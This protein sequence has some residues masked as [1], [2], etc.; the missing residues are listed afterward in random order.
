MKI[1]NISMKKFLVYFIALLGFALLSSSSCDKGL[2]L[3]TKRVEI[4]IL[5]VVNRI[6]PEAEISVYFNEGDFRKDKK[7]FA[8]GFSDQAGKFIVDLEPNT[9]VLDYYISVNKD[10]ADNWYDKIKFFVND[11]LE[12]SEAFIQITSSLESKLAGRNGKRWIQTSYIFNGEEF[13]RCE[14]RLVNIFKPNRFKPNSL[15][16]FSR[17]IDRYQS[18]N[19]VCNNPDKLHSVEVWELNKKEDG[20]FSS[21]FEK[22]F[23]ELTDTKMVVEYFP[24]NGVR[25]EE[26]F[27]LEQ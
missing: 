12:L 4:Q 18:K 2:A 22:K 23:I 21:R 20:F 25:I 24:T 5:D 13:N 8:T 17:V 15:F 11:S 10:G 3:P 19:S 14:Y 9:Q 27:E 1:I 6:V 16:N 26:T 7:A